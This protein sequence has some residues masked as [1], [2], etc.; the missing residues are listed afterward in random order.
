MM[1]VFAR[2]YCMPCR[3]MEPWVREMVVEHPTV[4][5]VEVNVDREAHEHL[6]RFFQITSVPA[7]VF[8]D[9]DGTVRQRHGGLAS[10]EEMTAMLGRLGWAE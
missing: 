5:I 2:D 6:G 4:D 9:R 7:I 3:I 10:K 8:L 1:I